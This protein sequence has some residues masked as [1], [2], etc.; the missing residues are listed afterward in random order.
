[1]AK[2]LNYKLQFFK[3]LLECLFVYSV[4]YSKQICML[5]VNKFYENIKSTG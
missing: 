1:M 4:Q 2:H 3:M 5:L